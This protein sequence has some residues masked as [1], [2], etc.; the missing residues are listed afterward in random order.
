MNYRDFS[1]DRCG[2]AVGA[3]DG[4]YATPSVQGASFCDINCLASYVSAC[5]RAVS[6]DARSHDPPGDLY[7]IIGRRGRCILLVADW[8]EQG[9]SSARSDVPTTIDTATT[10]T[11]ST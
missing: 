2:W 6:P 3:G 7:T 4:C 10:K 1:C 8:P 5:E 11:S 9:L